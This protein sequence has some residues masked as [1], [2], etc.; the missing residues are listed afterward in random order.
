MFLIIDTNRNVAAW[1]GEIRAAGVGTVIRYYCQNQS[2]RLRPAEALALAKA[3]LSVAVVYE[4]RA[5]QHDPGGAIEDFT[6]ARGTADAARAAEQAEAIAQPKGSPIYFAVDWDFVKP[7]ELHAI[8]DYFAAAKAELA[9]RYRVG[10]YGSGLVT[11]ALRQAG[12]AD[13]IWL[14]LSTGWSGYQKALASGHVALIQKTEKVWPGA[15]FGY[16]ENTVAPGFTDIGAF[17]PASAPVPVPMAH[18]AALYIVNAR[19][20]LNLRRGPG[21]EFDVVRSLPAGTLVHGMA[22]NGD[23]L[24]ADVE[25]DGLADGYLAMDFLK[26]TA[27]SLAQP[28]RVGMSPYQIAREELALG[29]QEVPGKADNPRIVAYHASTN[30]GPAPDELA[31]CSS[32]VNWCV[33]QSGLQGTNNK[34]AMSWHDDGWGTDVTQTPQEGDIVVFR[35]DGAAEPGGHVGFFVADAGAGVLVL[36]GNQGNRVSIA[37]YP[38]NGVLGGYSYRLLSIRRPSHL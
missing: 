29:V 1:A 24:L 25:G 16:D 38:K 22:Q 4:D 18:S 21:T 35:R 37:A 28:R 34:W 5:G 30:G 32:F 36:G 17:V 33:R 11:L 31:W 10:A 15:G 2:K 8:Q 20:G 6:A 26:L 19:N 7:A 27:G 14:S 9:G 12:L 3:G 13:Y 23:W